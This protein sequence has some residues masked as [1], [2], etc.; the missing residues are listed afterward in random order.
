[1]KSSTAKL[2]QSGAANVD[3]RRIRYREA[4]AGGMSLGDVSSFSKQPEISSVECG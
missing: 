4:L 1:M 3:R 2:F